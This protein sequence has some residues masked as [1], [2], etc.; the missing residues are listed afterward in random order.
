MFTVRTIL[1]LIFARI[2]DNLPCA[3]PIVMPDGQIIYEHGY[4]LGSVSGKEV[5]IILCSMP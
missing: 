5:G 3:T 4:R 2:V 1:F